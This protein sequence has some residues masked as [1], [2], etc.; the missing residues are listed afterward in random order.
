MLAAD[1]H[2]H[3]MFSSDSDTPVESMIEAAI[4]QG[5]TCFYLTDHHDADYPVGEDERD[6]MLDLDGYLAALAQLRETYQDR[7]QIRTGIELGLMAQ[8]AD[9]INAFA[10][11]Y[12]VDF[13]IG[14]SHLVQGQD[15]YYA[16]Y[17]E[18]KTEHQAYEEYFL[19]ILENAKVFD[20]FQVYGH[21]DYVIRYGPNKDLHYDPLDYYDIFKELLTVLIEKG[22][23]IEINTGSLYKGFSYPHPHET[24]LKIY[25]QLHGEII[26]VG[27]DAHVPQ[28]LG[29]GFEQAEAL[30]RSCGFGYYT[31]FENGKP[32]QMAL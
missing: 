9:K 17:Y 15:P 10:A 3:S 8:S 28:Y 14:S 16:Q 25:R 29:Y 26:T 20:C 11:R 13:I 18:G 12:P 4:R 31:L 23:G 19:S 30:L 32:C 21:L 2:V 5:R 22:K 6:F 24:I 1:C 27:S 7:I